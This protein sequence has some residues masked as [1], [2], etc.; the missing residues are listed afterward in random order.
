MRTLAGSRRLPLFAVIHHRGRRSGRSYATP[1]AARR[2][3]DG[4]VVPMTFGPQADWVQNVRTARG[5][6][7]RWHGA[8]Y[9]VV[10]PKVID[11][12][13]A[14][15]AFSPIERALV[16]LFGIEQFVRLRHA[17]ARENDPT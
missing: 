3:A 2:T 8:D 11:W 16:P 4:F 12:A 10:E 1:V 6:V 9:P 7:I 5:C 17:P 15:S 14:R 13:A